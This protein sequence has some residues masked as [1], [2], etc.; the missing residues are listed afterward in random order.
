MDGEVEALVVGGVDYGEADRIVHLLTVNGRLTAFAH[1]AK[2]SKRRFQGAL[3]P[4]TTIRASLSA[5]KKNKGGMP[6]LVS[7]SVERARLGLRRELKKI[8]LASYFAE[9]ARRVAPE[10]EPAEEIYALVRSALD[11]LLDQPATIAARRAFELALMD[12]LGYR[13][14]LEACVVCGKEA[15]PP[16]VDFNRGGA[17]CAAHRENARELGPKTMQWT[18]AMLDAAEFEPAGEF[19]AEWADRAARKLTGPMAEF[20]AVLLDRPPNA[21]ALLEAESL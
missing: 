21:L 19:G 9:V 20:F 14:M 12:R 15:A 13:P 10:S 6:T 17:L 18:A 16:Y 7:A 3:D 8:A 5:S 2:K 4:F 1:G 11:H